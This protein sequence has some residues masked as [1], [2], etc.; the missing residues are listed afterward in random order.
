M[1]PQNSNITPAMPSYQEMLIEAG[2]NLAAR[3]G[4]LT[5]RV[6]LII[7][8]L[9]VFFALIMAMRWLRSMGIAVTN[10]SFGFLLLLAVI[11]AL[12]LIIFYTVIVRAIFELEK[13]IWI[14]SYFDRRNL[15]PATSWKIAKK[16][17][18]PALKLR[19]HIFFKFYSPFISAI[20]LLLFGFGYAASKLHLVYTDY[21]KT[22]VTICL[23]LAI[24][25]FSYF[26]RVKLRY[27]WF[28]FLDFYNRDSF[29]HRQFFLEL[30][31]FNEVSK[32]ETFKKALVANFAADSLEA[33]MR[34]T[35]GLI[36]RGLSE[37]GAVLGVSALGKLFGSLI[38]IFSG[39]MSKQTA[40]FGKI[41]GVYLLYR[42][43]RTSSYGTDQEVN[44][45][46]YSL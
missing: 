14:D 35:T 3:K 29:T 42:F 18:W 12:I 5:K 37:V 2:R 22:V 38:Q 46:I 21:L 8:P 19:L 11:L 1:E 41:A 28:I 17:F 31:K 33:V 26:V 39:E 30:S 15:E 4:I 43:A 16:L 40:S 20:I 36:S 25:I 32:S 27:A 13:Y 45:Y 34:I 6:L 44:E 7:W 23:F 24:F 10:Q 9:L